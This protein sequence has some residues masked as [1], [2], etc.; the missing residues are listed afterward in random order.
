MVGGSQGVLVASSS[1]M[2]V[3]IRV[4]HEKSKR[5]RDHQS[6]PWFAAP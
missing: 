2:M 4:L 1:V 6:G 5:V 3:A